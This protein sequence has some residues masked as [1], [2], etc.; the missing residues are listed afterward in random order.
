M[1]PS[2]LYR[3]QA[4]ILTDN[5][6]TSPSRQHHFQTIGPKTHT[7]V[8]LACTSLFLFS[9]IFQIIDIEAHFGINSNRDLYVSNG[10]ISNK[11]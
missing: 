9:V 7:D 6:G 1:L 4:W 8:F 11:C 3:R 10:E 5:F 2:K